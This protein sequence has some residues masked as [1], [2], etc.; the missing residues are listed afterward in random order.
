LG[1]TAASGSLAGWPEKRNEAKRKSAGEKRGW[2]LSKSAIW[3]LGGCLE[4]AAFG[5]EISDARHEPGT[6]GGKGEG[7]R[8]FIFL[9]ER[10]SSDSKHLRGGKKKNSTDIRQRKT[11]ESP[12]KSITGIGSQSL[13]P[14]L[15]QQKKSGKK[16]PKK[17]FFS[18]KRTGKGQRGGKL[19][20]KA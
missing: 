11:D 5:D 3:Q 10:P 1:G 14:S 17:L 13:G 18:R 4:R 15:Q 19:G 6:K 12:T 9:R 8:R 7:E 20:E 16:S 2:E